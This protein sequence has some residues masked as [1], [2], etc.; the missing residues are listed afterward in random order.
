FGWQPVSPLGR[1]SA[2]YKHRK[3][4]EIVIVLD[5]D[6]KFDLVLGIQWLARHN[7]VDK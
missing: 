2:S 1:R 5:L 6:D 4:V 7:S 3:F